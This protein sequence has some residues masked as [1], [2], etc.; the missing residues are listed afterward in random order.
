M[1]PDLQELLLTPPAGFLKML[2]DLI[3]ELGSLHSSIFPTL[4][5]RINDHSEGELEDITDFIGDIEVQLKTLSLLRNASDLMIPQFSETELDHLDELLDI[6][7]QG[8]EELQKAVAW[9]YGV[10]DKCAEEN[11]EAEAEEISEEE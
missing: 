10:L 9:L 3:V 11:S 7:G 5:R 1:S 4:R 6:L 2:E 8:E